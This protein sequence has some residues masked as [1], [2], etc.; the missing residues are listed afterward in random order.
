M[1]VCTILLPQIRDAAKLKAALAQRL[2]DVLQ[3]LT[4]MTARTSLGQLSVG[5]AAAASAFANGKSTAAGED[6]VT[7]HAA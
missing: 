6:V 3:F 4:P 7:P 1:A 5:D 2:G